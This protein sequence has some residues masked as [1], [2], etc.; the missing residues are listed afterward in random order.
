M[1]LFKLFVLSLYTHFVSCTFC[2]AATLWCT[3]L[4]FLVCNTC[5]SLTL[6]G[7]G[8]G[9]SVLNW[10]VSKHNQFCDFVVVVSTMDAVQIF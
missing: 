1:L 6:P 9:Q 2:H 3:A 4:P 10:A 7:L 5:S 8:K